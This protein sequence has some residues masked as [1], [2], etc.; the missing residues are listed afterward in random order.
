MAQYILIV[1]DE[2]SL[3]EGLATNLKSKG[4]QVHTAQDGEKALEYLKSN[5][6]DL[7]LLDIRL[8][9]ISGYEVCQRLRLNQNNTPILMLTARDD[10]DDKIFGL[11]SG[12]DDYMTKP[13]DLNEL[14][15]RVEAMLRRK[16][17]VGT[18]IQSEEFH[19][20]SYWV[21][22]KTYQAQTE[23]G[24]VTLNKKEKEVFEIFSNN[25]GEVIS[26]KDLLKN[27]WDLPDHPNE[28]IVDNVIVN[29][30]KYFEKDSQ[31]PKHILNIRGV[32]YKFIL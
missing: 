4:Y 8:P 5:A 16:S 6:V 31:H 18:N 32:G 28:R 12:A 9:K 13:F 21:N 7:I 14:L 15:A 24:L 1:E 19:F 11:K 20:G 3:R 25:P 27:V 29:L 17:W 23:I 10:V 30:R 2:A 22:F 26:R